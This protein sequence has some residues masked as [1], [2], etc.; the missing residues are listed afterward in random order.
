MLK[1]LLGKMRYFRRILGLIDTSDPPVSFCFYVLMFIAAL[2]LCLSGTRKMWPSIILTLPAML[3]GGMDFLNCN[4]TCINTF[5]AGFNVNW[6]LAR[7]FGPINNGFSIEQMIIVLVVAFLFCMA[8]Y[9]LFVPFLLASVLLI[10]LRNFKIDYVLFEAQ[11]VGEYGGKIVLCAIV[12]LVLFVAAL[13][14]LKNERYL[15]KSLLALWFAAIGSFMMLLSF[16]RI[17]GCRI[18]STPF[19]VSFASGGSDN[20]VFLHTKVSCVIYAVH[21]GYFAGFQICRSLLVKKA[22]SFVL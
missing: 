13:I 14:A 3:V 21:V 5:L 6:S 4:W 2:F 12:L 20:S 17:T 7:V 16:E 15:R 8:V 10:V 22:R 11:N 9:K 19:P 1:M 18:L